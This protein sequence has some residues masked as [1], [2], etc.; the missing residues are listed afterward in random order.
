MCLLGQGIKGV[1]VDANSKPL[2]GINIK[3]IGT[4]FS[5]ST[6][7]KGMF[8]I[9]EEDENTILE[10]T[11]IGYISQRIKVGRRKNITI[12]L[13]PATSTLDEIQVI[14]Y[15][16]T[17]KR[18]NVGSVTTIKSEDIEK[19]AVTNPLAALQGRVPGLVVTGT[20]GLP[21]ASFNIQIRGQNNLPS[22]IV[23]SEQPMDNPLFIIDGVPF[24]PQNQNINQFNSIAS[25]GLGS[26]YNNRSAGLS[27][28]NSINPSDI[29]RI[30][31]LRDADATAIYGSRGG[32][33]VIL[34]TTKKGNRTA[35]RTE[36]TL[37][38]INGVSM[39]GKTMRM[40]NTKEYI[41]MRQE[42]LKNENV[43]PT[44]ALFNPGYAPDLLLFDKD[45]YTDWKDYFLGNTANNMIVNTTLS[46]GSQTTMFRIGAGFNK[47]TYIFPGDFSDNR[48]NFSL[49]I[50]HVSIDRKFNMN[51]STI[52]SYNK[53]NSSGTPN[54]LTAY[55][56]QPNFPELMDKD[57]NL[58]W[59]YKGHPL[60]I[61]SSDNPIA[62]LN[63]IYNISTINLN[64][65]L[66]LSYK[67]TDDIIFK[68][69][70]GY[71]TLNSKEYSG[72]PSTAI[73]PIRGSEASASF[74]KN[75]FSTWIIEPHFEYRKLF[76][77]NDLNI[78]FGGTVQHQWNASSQMTGTGYINDDLIRS[79]SAAPNRN[80]TDASSQY[81]YAALFGRI[82][83][84]L[85]GRYIANLNLRR[86]GSSRFGPSKQFGNFGSIG[87]AWIFSEE[88][89]LK[90][91]IPFLSFGKLRVSYGVT[92]NDA[93][94]DYLYLARW[95]TTN[96]SYDGKIGYIPQNLYNPLLHWASTKKS[97]I[98]L[99]LGFLKDRIL[100]NAAYYLN[101]SANQLV[102]YA[103]PA[104]T[105]FNSVTEN[106]NALVNN[107]G[108]EISIQSKN[109]QQKYFSWTTSLNLTI[110]NN[111]LVSFEGIEKS[112]YYNRYILGQS[113]NTV[114]G[115][116]FN[117]VNNETG[118]FQYLTANGELSSIPEMPSN[119]SLNDY[120]VIGSLDPKFY[121]GILNTVSYKN[122]SLD[123]HLDFR[124]QMGPNYLHQV[125]SSL[126]GMQFNV[127]AALQSRWQSPG[128]K[129]NIQRFTSSY[130]SGAYESGRRFPNSSG[131]YS[132]ASFI[133]CRN[134]SVSY[135]LPKLSEKLN[136]KNFRIYCSA[137]NLFTI[138][139]YQGNDPETQS[140]YGVPVLKTLTGGIQFSL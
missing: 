44:L 48:A 58:V 78:M 22:K 12:T 63:K 97:E 94:A 55:R 35:E 104:T 122:L 81:K 137:Q 90:N 91:K 83:Y 136:I 126:P 1:V 38:A 93:I 30:E 117:G 72:I 32:N 99:E 23:G 133:K 36:F 106:W 34:I 110:P 33:G 88:S 130:S 18:Y 73:N 111:K 53:N 25:P 87:L 128:D 10:V 71:N 76:D 16:V 27:P 132:N 19:Q 140:F 112:S 109:I 77:G 138:T 116:R 89:F 113:L 29:E 31:V 21:G 4:T 131:A 114:L 100:F 64:S 95:A 103:L 62:Y 46:G 66:F 50:N 54:L 96:Y 79:I 98:G 8:V 108:L 17:T 86:D 102:S 134:I 43:T 123:I 9:R 92:G 129:A 127:P 118:L 15:G 51:F 125:Y 49:N 120:V 101:R 80:V 14:G 26:L 74:G 42:A 24:A 41:E 124:N 39:V 2:D 20:S 11:A 40:M 3:V 65:N 5:T 115:F 68:T 57:G 56:L 107:I 37:N 6:D 84:K 13:L 7:I 52:Y 69:S 59:E 135:S 85:Y 139:G 119:R 45:R 70:F 67:F 105:G 60:G 28:F 121:G 75:D 47:S 61:E 82:N